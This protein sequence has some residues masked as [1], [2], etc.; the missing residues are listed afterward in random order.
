MGIQGNFAAMVGIGIVV[1]ILLC[2][3][4]TLIKDIKTKNRETKI[5]NAAEKLCVPGA[6]FVYYGDNGGGNPFIEHKH[7]ITI[8]DINGD[9]CKFK[10]D[11]YNAK[12]PNKIYYTNE[13]SWQKINLYRW[14][15]QRHRDVEITMPNQN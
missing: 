10:E 8:I 13:S 7:I 12:V 4:D 15:T 5:R 3:I 1:L 9:W 11:I 6:K 14:I 2:I